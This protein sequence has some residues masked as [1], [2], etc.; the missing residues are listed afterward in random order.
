MNDCEGCITSI[1]H[2]CVGSFEG[3]LQLCPCRFCA[4]KVMCTTTCDD[5]EEVRDKTVLNSS[6]KGEIE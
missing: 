3:L 1:D 5:Y 6:I 2:G 4:V